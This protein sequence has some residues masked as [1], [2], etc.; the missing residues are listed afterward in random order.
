MGVIGR[1]IETDITQGE[2]PQ[3]GI[4]DRMHQHIGIAV[5]IQA[6]AIGVLQPLAAQD[7]RPAWHQAVNVVAVADSQLHRDFPDPWSVSFVALLTGRSWL[8]ALGWGTPLI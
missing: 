3:K 6:Q 5:A 8:G 1:K 2:G 7:Q 4:H